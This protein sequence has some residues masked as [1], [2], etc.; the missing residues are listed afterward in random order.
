MDQVEA[1]A[2]F[3]AE[4]P[5]VKQEFRRELKELKDFG[6][7]LHKLERH[8]TAHKQAN[9]NE[10]ASSAKLADTLEQTFAKLVALPTPDDDRLAEN[11]QLLGNAIAMG[12][13]VIHELAERKRNL[14]AGLERMCKHLQDFKDT[15]IGKA[16]TLLDDFEKRE[17]AY[18]KDIDKQISRRHGGHAQDTD[19]TEQS[20]ARARLMLAGFDFSQHM[21]E[22]V[23]QRIL[24]Y[25]RHITAY[26]EGCLDQLRAH[27]DQLQLH[28]NTHDE[29]LSRLRSNQDRRQTDRQAL[30]RAIEQQVLQGG[31]EDVHP[32]GT[33][34]TGYL[35]WH[36]KGGLTA[37]WVR[38]YATYDR[39]SQMMKLFDVASNTQIEEMQ[40]DSCVQRYSSDTD[41]KN[42]FEVHNRQGNAF[43]LQALN[44]TARQKW[45]A[46]MGGLSPTKTIRRRK[47]KQAIEKF[48]LT[49][50]AVSFIQRL[51][52]QIERDGL[53]EQGIYRIPGQTSV[54]TRLVNSAIER[55]KAVNLQE[56][57]IA[58]CASALK[59]YLRELEE[60][61]MTTALTP[62]FVKA[63][64]SGS[65]DVNELVPNL[66]VAVQRLPPLNRSV[67]KL[68]FLH[69]HKVAEHSDANSMTAANLG[70]CFGPTLFRAGQ[71]DMTS[72]IADMQYYNRAAELL[73][74]HVKPIFDVGS[75]ES[76]PSLPQTAAAVPP[77]RALAPP[78]PPPYVANDEEEA[79]ADTAVLARTACVRALYDC[80]GDAEDELSFMAGDLIIDVKHKIK[81]DK[82]HMVA[83]C[84]MARALSPL[85]L[86]LSQFTAIMDAAALLSDL[87]TRCF[88]DAE[89]SEMQVA[90]TCEAL[91]DH[92]LLQRL[93]G[94]DPT[95][96][97]W[98]KR[99]NSSLNASSNPG[100]GSLRLLRATLISCNPLTFYTNC[101]NWTKLLLRPASH[102]A[103]LDTD[104]CVVLVDILATASQRSL[105]DACLRK[106]V[107]PPSYHCHL[108]QAFL[109]FLGWFFS[110]SIK[111]YVA[112]SARKFCPTF[113]KT[114]PRSVSPA[115]SPARSQNR[116]S[117]L[118]VKALSACFA[119]T[120][121]CITSKD[122]QTFWAALLEETVIVC[123]QMGNELLPGLVD[124]HRN[125][126]LPPDYA[127]L[128][129]AQAEPRRTQEL[130]LLIQGLLTIVAVLLRAPTG[131]CVDVHTNLLGRLLSGIF[132]VDWHRAATLRA[133]GLR[134]TLVSHHITK[135][136]TCAG[137]VL[138]AIADASPMLCLRVMSCAL[139]SLNTSLAIFV[140]ELLPVPTCDG[141]VI[142][143]ALDSVWRSL[144]GCPMLLEAVAAEELAALVQTCCQASTAIEHSELS[145]DA[146]AINTGLVQ[147]KKGGKR[148]VSA[149]NSSAGPIN[150][151][152]Q[153]PRSNARLF[154]TALR[155]LEAIVTATPVVATKVSQKIGYHARISSKLAGSLHPP[156]PF[157]DPTVRVATYRLLARCAVAIPAM[158]ADFANAAV[159]A[160]QRGTL[161]V[162]IEVRAACQDHLFMLDGV[163][164]P[165]SPAVRVPATAVV[166]T[167][168]EDSSASAA[169]TDGRA[170]TAALTTPLDSSFAQ[171][172]SDTTPTNTEA[173]PAQ[174]EP[175]AQH[176]PLA[177]HPAAITASSPQRSVLAP[178]TSSAVTPADPTAGMT[179]PTVSTAS[180]AE[181]QAEKTPDTTGM[182]EPKLPK[183][184]APV[185]EFTDV[186][187][188]T[189]E[190][191]A[192]EVAHSA[193]PDAQSQ[194]SAVGTELED[195]D[196]EFGD[197]D[198][199]DADPDSAD[200]A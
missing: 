11:L 121:S 141:E 119:A 135:L 175:L 78:R 139:P 17:E 99:L 6:T 193:P 77:K 147:R 162:M 177:H 126:D 7:I 13:S 159:S 10:A 105:P 2:T 100:S 129:L 122:A 92:G 107:A 5:A 153:R 97:R 194:L 182:P 60:P 93:D 167:L 156:I 80:E 113:S 21:E 55:G 39:P 72:S 189:V 81:S 69:L 198:L 33:L 138:A 173:P 74:E 58:S 195:S 32:E 110:G 101:L 27:D 95:V 188:T 123:T 160:L 90:L 136:H 50:Q 187:T 31:F 104:I 8:A 181:T 15:Y 79:E 12:F 171:N 26:H 174:T 91:V 117:S 45:I 40:I 98:S 38:V 170:P 199:V 108:S 134:R 142:A 200:E 48:E 87:T 157:D 190:A 144:Q 23:D 180:A 186:D 116:S 118:S 42:C 197:D 145:L 59:H 52:S 63:I 191:T 41:R 62:L 30:M 16:Q 18:Y 68:L 14:A 102:G 111:N 61:L 88:E 51:M 57:D 22:W 185:A 28:Q 114:F 152:R 151:T 19:T 148:T 166:A 66:K 37:S 184:E 25:V 70:R 154:V 73:V 36:R 146:K 29:A 103:L 4:G 155:V 124:G 67:A 192:S 161:D 172:L 20:R 3:P 54:Y 75:E 44:A 130:L 96:I 158:S 86:S 128:P 150:F 9:E 143:V 127:S 94:T 82:H 132:A 137:H 165:R 85:S 169:P 76:S 71:G 24:M 65:Q 84:R 125:Q 115:L 176:E 149:H 106:H 179:T 83:S 35:Y 196:V 89:P 131:S 1:Q 49:P 133:S 183:V 178:S 47:V 120:A 64:A 109:L 34:I 164:K 46:A 168:A 163:L 140:A 53:T 43:M 112:T 56:V